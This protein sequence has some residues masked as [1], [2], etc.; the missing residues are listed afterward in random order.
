MTD[1]PVD[2]VS[3]PRDHLKLAARALAHKICPPRLGRAAKL[4]GRAGQTWTAQQPERTLSKGALS[5][6]CQEG[7]RDG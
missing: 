6:R 3:G 4:R 2:F 7:A 1:I 5:Q